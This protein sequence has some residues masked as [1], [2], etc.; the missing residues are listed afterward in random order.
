M[1]W[2][3]KPL[4]IA[5]TVGAMVLL[6]VC[7][8]LIA[9]GVTT[10]KEAGLLQVCWQGDKA[11]YTG[12]TEVAP[13]ESCTRTEELVWPQGK[14][15]LAVAAIAPDRTTPLDPGAVAREGVD[16]AAEDI[17]RQLGFDLFRAVADPVGAAVVVEIGV[18]VE[19]G[20]DGRARGGDG[21]AATS[22]PLGRAQHYLFSN[23]RG[24]FCDIDIYAG[25]GSLRHEYLVVHHELLHC[26]GLAH[27]ADNPASAIY[28]F[29]NDDTMWERMQAARI[30]DHDR[31]LL[32]SRYMKK[33][34]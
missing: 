32:R 1:G 30:T 4:N 28:P 5:I 9:Y 23:G 17:N 10:H 24:L 26:A 19:A 21:K 3:K 8:V 16:E 27:D 14:I 33:I 22:S 11:Q 25:I 15:P 6:V 12:G 2:F 20:V 34:H 7:A 13:N 18:P 29:T 31:E